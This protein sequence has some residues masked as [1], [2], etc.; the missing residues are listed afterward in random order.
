MK[1]KIKSSWPYTR[2]PDVLDSAFQR[3]IPFQIDSFG[4]ALNAER[5]QNN[6]EA[7]SI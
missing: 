5:V 1:R 4:I 6:G 2:L 3:T 7:Q